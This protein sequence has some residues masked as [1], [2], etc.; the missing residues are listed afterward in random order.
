MVNVA[1]RPRGSVR[2]AMLS[3]FGLAIGVL[4][5]IGGIAPAYALPVAAPLPVIG[6]G[7][8]ATAATAGAMAVARA[9]LKR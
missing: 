8:I 9:L 7:F 1:L 2:S 3:R 4:A 6:V 5:L